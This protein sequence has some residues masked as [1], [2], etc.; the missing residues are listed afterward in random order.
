[1][2]FCLLYIN[3]CNIGHV[4]RLFK[5][6]NF[7]FQLQLHSEIRTVQSKTYSRYFLPKQTLVS[8]T[9]YSIIF[10]CFLFL[11]A[12]H[13]SSNVLSFRSRPSMQVS[14]RWVSLVCVNVL[15]NG[16]HSRFM[17]LNPRSTTAVLVGMIHISWTLII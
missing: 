6:C 16:E 15:R 10:L 4:Q 17:V 11:K 13:S 2:L 14:I 1:M 3:T 5:Y 8:H 9:S 12:S 7:V